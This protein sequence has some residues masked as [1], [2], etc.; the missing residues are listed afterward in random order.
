MERNHKLVRLKSK[1]KQK[2]LIPEGI[3]HRKQRC[4]DVEVIFGNIKH[5][6][7][8]KRC[9]LKGIDKVETEI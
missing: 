6:M 2:L 1:A 8:F 4:W 9:I 3:T 7:K 5:N